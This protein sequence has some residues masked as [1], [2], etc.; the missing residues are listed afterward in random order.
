MDLSD[1]RPVIL[2]NVGGLANWMIKINSVSYWSRGTFTEL[3]CR[4]YI[5]ESSQKKKTSSNNIK[6]GGDTRLEYARKG[7]GRVIVFQI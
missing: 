5:T 3:S 7:R 2:L 1:T 4:V 6:N